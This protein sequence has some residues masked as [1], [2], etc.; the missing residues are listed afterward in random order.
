MALASLLYGIAAYLLF[1]GTF[2][3]AIGFVGNL[4]VIVGKLN[5]TSKWSRI[6]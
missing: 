4:P 3:Y 6:G 5:P 1:L 2:V